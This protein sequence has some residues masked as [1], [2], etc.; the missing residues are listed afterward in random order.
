MTFTAA[1]G[2]TAL[3]STHDELFKVVRDLSDDQLLAPSGATEW[4]VAQVLSHLGSGA[5]I[6]AATLRSALEGAGALPEGFN[7]GVWERWN[8]MSPREQADGFLAADT[9]LVGAI[10]ALTAEQRDS[11]QVDLGFLPAP[12]PVATYVAMR[13]GEAAAHSWD[14]RV[15]FD[16][17]AAIE[18][19]TAQLLVAQL[20]GQLGFLLGFTAKADAVS[21]PA[22]VDLVGLDHDLSLGETVALVPQGGETTATFEGGADAVARLMSGRLTTAHTPAAVTVSGNVSLEDLRRVFPGY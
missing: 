21:Q 12:V 20:A 7:Q 15:A 17:D 8:A 2:I 6:S 10:E 11:L 4:P 3:R 22:L 16:E 13:L 5:E 14:V 9:T 19:E 1:A 18:D